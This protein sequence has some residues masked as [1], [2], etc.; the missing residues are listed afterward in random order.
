MTKED[1]RLMKKLKINMLSRGQDVKGQGVGSAFYELVDL[2][3]EFAGDSLD[4]TVN[5]SGDRDI[6][7]YHT[8]DPGNYFRL[9]VDNKITVMYCHFLPET[10]E[11]SISLPKPA[12]EI[13]AMYFLDFY[14]SA[15]YLVVVN[16]IFIDELVKYDIPRNNIV[17]IP[18]YVSKKDFY[19][20][21][22]EIK[23]E[24]RKKYGVA[25]DAF[26]VLGVGQVQTRKGV[27]SFVEVAK[28]SPEMTFVWAGGFSFGAIT[29]GYQ[30]LKAIVE[31]P[32]S[33]VIFTDIVPRE[34][35]NSIF[36]MADVLFMP[37]YNELF[38]MAI[39]EAVN[40]E[41]PL[42][43]R[44]LELYEDI[45]F[46]YLSGDNDDDFVYFLNKLKDSDKFYEETK[47]YS[48]EISKFYSKE[49][50]GQQWID[51]YQRI[52]QEQMN[53]EISMFWETKYFEK[54]RSGKARAIVDGSQSVNAPLGNITPGDKLVI[55]SFNNRKLQ[56]TVKEVFYHENTDDEA[57]LDF[58][59]SYQGILRLD[60][61][62]IKKYANRTYLQIVE[63]SEIEDL[64]I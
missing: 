39:L 32:P 20:Q 46:N 55:T 19:V 30:E 31:N 60:A 58:L 38:P 17:Y 59:L 22:N 41:T 2:L 53:H 23:L 11:G 7:H 40:T 37:S 64:S 44:N 42:L 4:I 15:D 56:A 10:L 9:K 21:S 28:Q 62:Q 47:N 61:S 26:V 50:V 14:K 63:I 24:T 36:N 5:E 34:E 18:N 3:K 1:F 43:L 48:I 51:F 8:I 16:P 35:M 29:D 27:L 12:F 6:D 25:E 57:H 13:F 49:H 45:L 54:L 52:Y 33:N